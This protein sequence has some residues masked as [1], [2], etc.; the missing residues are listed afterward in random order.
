M[1]SRNIRESALSYTARNSEMD[2]VQSTHPPLLGTDG[3]VFTYPREY[4]NLIRAI[5]LWIVI[6]CSS[7]FSSKG[8]LDGR[9]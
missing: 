9:S 2:G 7:S 1:I 3:G 4:P 8:L 6:P 5:A